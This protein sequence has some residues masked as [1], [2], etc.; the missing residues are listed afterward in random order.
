MGRI[1]V[2]W[3][4]WTD[5]NS[6]GKYIAVRYIRTRARIF[7]YTHTRELTKTENGRAQSIIIEYPGTSSTKH[8]ISRNL[9]C[10]ARAHIGNLKIA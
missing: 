10:Q 8:G 9:N 6:V 2:E 3:E 1:C 4:E 5:S 7:T